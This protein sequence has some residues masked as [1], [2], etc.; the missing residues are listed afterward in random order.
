MQKMQLEEAA[1]ERARSA[2]S[3][4]L[5]NSMS[6]GGEACEKQTLLLTDG[7]TARNSV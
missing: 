4:S 3:R 5:G 2:K 6:R 7:S 1:V